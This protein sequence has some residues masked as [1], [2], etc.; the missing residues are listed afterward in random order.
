MGEL[1]GTTK[2]QNQDYST[3][4]LFLESVYIYSASHGGQWLA[5]LTEFW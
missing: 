4:C 5:E 1:A 3:G 2:Y